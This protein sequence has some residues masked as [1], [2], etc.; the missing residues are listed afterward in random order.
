MRFQEPDQGYQQS[1][2]ACTGAKLVCLDSG[3]VE[4]PPSAPFVGKRGG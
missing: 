4:E 1:R 3:Q 2:I